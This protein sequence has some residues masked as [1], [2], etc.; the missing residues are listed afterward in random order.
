MNQ[1]KRKR[2]RKKETKRK[3]KKKNSRRKSEIAIRGHQFCEV[4]SIQYSEGQTKILKRQQ[5]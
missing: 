2:K 1:K 5:Y 4:D 3:I